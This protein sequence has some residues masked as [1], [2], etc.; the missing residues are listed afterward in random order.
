LDSASKL[1][2]GIENDI[3]LLVKPEFMTANGVILSEEIKNTILWKSKQVFVKNVKIIFLQMSKML[4][5]DLSGLKPVK[6]NIS[7]S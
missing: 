6:R 3:T 5:T 4:H 7:I 2:F 1:H